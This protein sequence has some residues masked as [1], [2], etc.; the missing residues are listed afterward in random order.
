MTQKQIKL[1]AFL[2]AP[3]HHVA[4]WRHGSA[5]PD[6]G[7]NFKAYAKIAQE[8]EAAKFDLLFLDDI[9]AVKDTSR[10]V[11]PRLSRAAFFEPISLLSGL[12][13]VTERIGLVGTVSTTYND[14]YTLARKFASLDLISEGRGGW[15]LVTS[16]TDEEAANYGPNAICR[17]TSAMSVPRNLPMSCWA[18][19]AAMRMTPSAAIRKTAFITTRTSNMC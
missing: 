13:A 16:N 15:N 6:L 8:A 1:G 2:M 3:G 7:A 18:S 10:D 19:G 9:V 5:Q 4:A 12:A 11:G 14:P 17:I